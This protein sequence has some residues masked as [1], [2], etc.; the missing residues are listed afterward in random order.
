MIEE[1]SF[2]KIEN[3]KIKSP[4]DR[5]AEEDKLQKRNWKEVYA[6]IFALFSVSLALYTSLSSTG[7]DFG[8]ADP[9]AQA[10]YSSADENPI[11][12]DS[13]IESDLNE[14][15]PY[16]LV[17]DEKLVSM[18]GNGDYLAG[19]EITRRGFYDSYVNDQK[20]KLDV[21]DKHK[22]SAIRGCITAKVD[23]AHYYLGTF[24]KVSVIVDGK[25]TRN[26]SDIEYACQLFKE[27]AKKSNEARVVYSNACM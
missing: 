21:V 1:K 14:M 8:S 11:L 7:F 10:E 3:V 18:L 12:K 5:R 20:I 2:G 24:S 6:A 23:V 15:S 4:S 13:E 27:S 19:C 17:S 22:V 16:A 9:V 26:K 25:D